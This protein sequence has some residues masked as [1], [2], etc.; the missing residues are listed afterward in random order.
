MDGQEY[1]GRLEV[2][3]DDPAGVQRGERGQ[4]AQTDRQRVRGAQRSA[5]QP[6]GQR[7]A[8]QELH[9]DEQ[10][11]GVLADFIDLADVRMVD[12][13]RSPGLAP[14]ALTRRLVAGGGRQHLHGDRALEPIVARGVDNAHAAFSELT[15]DRIAANASRDLSSGSARGV[16]RR[17]RGRRARQPLVEGAEASPGRVMSLLI[18]HANADHTPG[19]RRVSC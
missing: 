12:A 6:L 16:R 4:H 9:R 19:R 2:P 10:P 14:Q 15:F 17:I 11:A 8:F 1:V 13:R 3:V 18:Y 5:S 7:F